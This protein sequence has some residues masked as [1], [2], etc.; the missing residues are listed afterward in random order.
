MNAACAGW[1]GLNERLGDDES[2][3]FA[4]QENCFTKCCESTIPN[5]M[6]VEITETNILWLMVEARDQNA[7]SVLRMLK[8]RCPNHVG[9]DG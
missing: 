4:L 1:V 2:I 3:A 8:A 5:L 7:A 9:P 6:T